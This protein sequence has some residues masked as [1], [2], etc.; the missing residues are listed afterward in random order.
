MFIF[1]KNAHPKVKVNVKEC[2]IMMA[3]FFKGIAAGAMIGAAAGMLMY[4]QMDR[5]TRSRIKKSGRIVKNAAEDAFDSMR[6][7]SR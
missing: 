4:P 7:M 6:H 3:K 1:L 5:T 2:I